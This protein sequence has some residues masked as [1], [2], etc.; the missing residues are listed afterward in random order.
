MSTDDKEFIDAHLDAILKASGS[1]LKHYSMHSVREG[2]RKALRNA[3]V[4]ATRPSPAK[5][6]SSLAKQV[7]D[8]QAEYDS[9]PPE[10][11]AGVV[12]QGSSDL[13]PNMEREKK[14]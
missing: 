2:M 11:R 1:A 7:A 14:P 6:P 13:R 3:I 4:C 10:R 12:L 5:P 8:A 9:W